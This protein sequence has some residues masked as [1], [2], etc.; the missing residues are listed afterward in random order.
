MVQR[1][2]KGKVPLIKV[3]E[4][5]I[6]ME[7]FGSSLLIESTDYDNNNNYYYYVIQHVR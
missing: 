3:L 5:I 4:S 1:L 6:R 7:T 2:L